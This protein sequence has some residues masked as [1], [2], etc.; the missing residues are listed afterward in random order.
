VQLSSSVFI[1]PALAIV[2]VMT[3][4]CLLRARGLMLF[5]F[6]TRLIVFLLRDDSGLIHRIETTTKAARK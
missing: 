6:S 4:I 3:V 1:I 2:F 5:S